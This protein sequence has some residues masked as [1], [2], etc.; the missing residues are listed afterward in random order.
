MNDAATPPTNTT[1]ASALLAE[2]H[3]PVA[4]ALGRLIEH[5]ERTGY[6][7]GYHDR[8]DPARSSLIDRTATEIYLS[9]IQDAG[10]DDDLG[11]LARKAY[12]IAAPLIVARGEW[13]DGIKTDAGDP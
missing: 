1:A 10:V 6:A 5:A 4:D 2:L 12:E 13:I 11:P 7:R 9:L 3:Q 8:H